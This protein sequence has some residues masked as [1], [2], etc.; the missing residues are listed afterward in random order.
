MNVVIQPQDRKSL[1][2]VV[3]T[4]GLEVRIPQQLDPAGKQVQQF[5]AD[6]LAH[7]PEAVGQGRERPYTT[8]EIRA[9]IDAWA[10]KLGVKVKRLQIRPM[11]R[12]WGSMSGNGNLTLAE[13]VRRLPVGL[14]EYIIVHELLHIRHPHHAR[15]FKV[16]F[17]L[18]LPD[19]R[20]REQE[21][22]AWMV[23]RGS[24]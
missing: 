18:A 1:A 13:D 20:E 11:R 6:G 17:S 23:V 9:M 19:W 8:A 15:K 22:A 16:A 3:T 14:I 2:L 24:G 12:K 5:I 21:L 4:D 10:E 7:L